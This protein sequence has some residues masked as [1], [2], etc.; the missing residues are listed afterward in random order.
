MKPFDFIDK[1]LG[2]A[3]KV[4]ILRYFIATHEAKTGRGIANILSLS[5]PAAL[6]ALNHLARQG[7]LIKTVVGKS[8]HFALNKRPLVVRKAL[9]PLFQFEKHFLEKVGKRIQSALPLSVEAAVLYGS[10]TR[11]TAEPQSDWDILLLCT[12][13]KDKEVIGE[14][15]SLKTIEWAKEFSNA[16]DIKVLTTKEFKNRFLR[17]DAFV[18]N[19]YNDYIHSKI[20]NPLFGKSLLEIMGEKNDK[21]NTR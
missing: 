3:I 14:V 19:I 20:K 17:G 2:N 4:K 7:I 15:L 11:G 16:F 12:N 9:I 8:H 18:R 10:L 1:I 5:P 6:D 21:K 13:G